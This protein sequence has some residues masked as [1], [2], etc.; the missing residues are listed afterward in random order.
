[1]KTKVASDGKAMKMEGA[2]NNVNKLQIIRNTRL[3]TKAG[4]GK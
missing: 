3:R 4:E 1:M 2:N